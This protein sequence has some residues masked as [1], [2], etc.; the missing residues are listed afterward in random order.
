[1]KRYFMLML[2]VYFGHS[3]QG[4][5]LTVLEDESGHPVELATIT[6]SNSKSTLLTHADGRVDIASL[7]D[8]E[9]IV[10]RSMGYKTVR[11][12]FAQLAATSFVIRLLRDDIA[13]DQIVISATKWNQSSSDV[14]SKVT[15]LSN[16]EIELL[17]P[18]TAADL[19]GA[20]GE[21]FIQKSQQ[22]GGSP[23]IRGFATNRLL[24]AV[25]GV[26]MNTAIFRGGNIQNVI[27]LDPFATE[28]VEVLFGPGSVIYGSDAIGGVMSFQT[29]MPQVSLDDKP[30]IKGKA[31][32]RTSSANKEQTGHF[33]INAGW[34]KWAWL[35]SFSSF[36]FGDLRMGSHGPEEYLRP[37]FV[38]RHG[39]S[40]VII[41][42]EDPLMQVPTG[43][44]Q[45]NF[46]QKVLFRPSESFDMQY[47]YHYSATSSYSRYDRHIRY[48]SNGQPRYGEWSYGPQKWQM[49]HVQIQHHGYTTLYDE[50][51]LRVALQQFE[52]S[53]IDRDI[54]DVIRHIRV[55]EVDA[56]SANLDFIK[57][58]GR[59]DFL[60]YG[61]EYVWN[62]VRSTGTD[63][64]ILTSERADGPAR[65]PQAT[66]QTAGAYINAQ[67]RFS[68]KILLQL[69]LRYSTYGLDAEFD[70]RF[71]PFP[72]TT[73]SLSNGALTGS[74]GVNW[75]PSSRWTFSINASSG[76]RSPNVDDAGK[77]F[78]SEPGIV[79]VPNPD[80][81]AEYAY[82]AEAGFAGR[83]G[84][85]IRL[86]VTGYYTRLNDALVRR[87]FTFNGQD[88]IFYDGELS[89]VQAVQNAAFALVYG[90]QAGIQ[91]HAFSG[92]EFSADLNYQKGEEELEDG[93][94]SPS[95]HAPPLFGMGKVAYRK[96][97]F[98]LMLYT[99]F[100]ARR[101]FEDLP[102]EEQNNR[103]IYAVDSNGN[104]WS[105]GW[106][107]LHFKASCPLNETF[108]V[109]AGLENITD[110]RY[111][112]YSSGL[113]APGR[114][115][116]LSLQAVF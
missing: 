10:V 5:I 79:I 21:V 54:Q 93:T 82:N 74:V 53:R 98:T 9:T 57:K 112:P 63:E 37:F 49:H 28:R 4:Q 85:H 67:R 12:S 46:M 42:N 3:V 36:D 32:I 89:R 20:S 91:I 60:Y 45:I 97:G 96:D 27:N 62:D 70:T 52:E 51:A 77:V 87:D 56:Y 16:R 22:G 88:S 110:L 72:Y 11:T 76:F 6:S 2:W 29:L 101:T 40:D 64:N 33:D 31:V 81:R 30:Y 71:Y 14:P 115:V 47:A 107:T 26:R 50:V 44:D 108:S 38:Q 39:Q 78:D 61:A 99:Q 13:L 55:E 18:Q 66:W 58:L 102:P 41:A 7:K 59:R 34:K 24:Y 1:M 73:A 15:T 100:S 83:L 90:V 86:D 35:S 106:M 103:E 113:V 19:L 95:R 43:Y 17:Q 111:R 65:Y 84:D 114:N 92:F 105:P 116:V 75:Q 25:D 94:R 69:G 80:L 109:G 68:D 104:P 8:A 23:M 48:R